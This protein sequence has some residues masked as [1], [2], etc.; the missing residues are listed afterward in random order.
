MAEG[1][2]PVAAKVQAPDWELKTE[3]V[4]VRR[5][6]EECLRG[7]HVPRPLVPPIYASSTYVLDSAKA[8]EELSDSNAAVSKSILNEVVRG[9]R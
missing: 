7:T 6:Y 5:N 8:G 9:T 2:E 3:T 1:V 4:L